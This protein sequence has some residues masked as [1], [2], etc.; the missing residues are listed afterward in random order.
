MYLIIIQICPAQASM[1]RPG[2]RR[3]LTCLKDLSHPRVGDLKK[4]VPLLVHCPTGGKGE[5]RR[6][7]SKGVSHVTCVPMRPPEPDN[8][9]CHLQFDYLPSE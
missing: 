4:C 9:A 1:S 6:E 2:G 5:F 3:P 7:I 8:L